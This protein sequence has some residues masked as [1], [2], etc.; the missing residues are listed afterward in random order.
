MNLHIETGISQHTEHVDLSETKRDS[1]LSLNK[2]GQYRV[3]HDGLLAQIEVYDLDQV[4]ATAQALLAIKTGYLTVPY[5]VELYANNYVKKVFRMA[6]RGNDKGKLILDPTA[7]TFIHCLRDGTELV[8]EAK[9]IEVD[10]KQTRRL[11][12]SC[13]DQIADGGAR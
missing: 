5:L 1:T 8:V 2:H 7:S 3:C 10:E 6:T 13:R 4:F 9:T 12:I 11:T